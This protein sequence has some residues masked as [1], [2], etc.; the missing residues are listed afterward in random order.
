MRKYRLFIEATDG[1]IIKEPEPDWQPQ[2]FAFVSISPHLE[3][4]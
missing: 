3:E 2:A 4:K 1:E